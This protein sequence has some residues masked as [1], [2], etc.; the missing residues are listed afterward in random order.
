MSSANTDIR[1]W[2]G[3][4]P[5]DVRSCSIACN[6]PLASA[7]GCFFLSFLNYFAISYFFFVTL[8]LLALISTAPQR[9]EAFSQVWKII[10]SYQPFW[11]ARRLS[12]LNSH[13]RALIPEALPR[14]KR[15]LHKDDFAKPIQVRNYIICQN[16]VAEQSHYCRQ[17][18]SRAESLQFATTLKL[19]VSTSSSVLHLGKTMKKK[20]SMFYRQ[21]ASECE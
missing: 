5:R 6:F 14:F 16:T 11:S 4:L 13:F 12:R 18:R 15:P 8:S 3:V 9:P 21:A 17:H 7:T 20:T 10:L 2:W 19:F 1:Y